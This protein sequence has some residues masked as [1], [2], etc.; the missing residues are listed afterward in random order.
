[1]WE[2]GREL[3][4]SFTSACELRSASQEIT[5]ID[6]QFLFVRKLGDKGAG[7]TDSEPGKLGPKARNTC[8]A[9]A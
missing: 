2:E 6:S 7:R 4:K 8:Y 5:A 9:S 3:H 1:M